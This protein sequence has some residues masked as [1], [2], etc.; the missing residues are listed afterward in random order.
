ML[1]YRGKYRVIYEIDKRTG[2]PLEFTFLPCRI[3]R[4]SDISRYNENTLSAYIPSIKITNKLLKVYPDIFK[5]FRI[6]DS[7]AILLFPESLIQ[8]AA[9]ILKTY[10]K[11]QNVSP[12]SKRNAK[13]IQKHG[14]KTRK[15]G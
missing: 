2:K 7:E 3:K 1:K 15:A 4:G 13:F 5:P 8:E 12:R 6:G 11:G 10:T 9:A 14:A